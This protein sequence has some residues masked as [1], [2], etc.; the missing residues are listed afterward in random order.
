MKHTPGPWRY[1]FETR[2]IR[3]IPTNYWLATI[4][5]WDGAVN[6]EA[7]A[8]LIAAAPDLLEA[9]KKVANCSRYP[10]NESEE[11]EFALECLREIARAAISKIEGRE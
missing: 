2:T 5:S 1:E 8:H 11:M 7:N 9:L 4:D 10:R 3:S 6:N